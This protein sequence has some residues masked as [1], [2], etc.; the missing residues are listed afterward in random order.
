MIFEWKCPRCATIWQNHSREEAPRCDCARVDGTLDIV[1]K[2]FYGSVQVGV[3]AFKPHFNH[4]VGEHVSSSR[5]FDE[6]LRRAGDAAGSE[7]TRIDPGESPRP[8]EDDHIFDTQMKTITDRKI[9]PRSL[10]Q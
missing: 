1:C 9:D 5:Q 6:A 8:T 10:V 4:A 2:R 7:Y 3:S